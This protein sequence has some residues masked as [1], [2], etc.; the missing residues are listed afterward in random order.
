MILGQKVPALFDT[1][2]QISTMSLK[3]ADALGLS[4]T[5]KQTTKAV[6]SVS[7][8]IVHGVGEAFTSI[9]VDKL[10]PVDSHFLVV[11]SC[12]YPII[13]GVDIMKCLGY[14]KLDYSSGTMRIIPHAIQKTINANL[15]REHNSKFV[16]NLTELDVTLDRD[17]TLPPL[18][19]NYLCVN[20]PNL[21]RHD[22]RTQP[23]SPSTDDS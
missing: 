8:H 17:I 10:K 21:Y 19:D 11:D 5:M 23:H 9:K 1:G 20:A 2:A 14:F 4:K 3:L 22:L 15:P 13:L 16:I 18:S 7:N 6:R 12:R